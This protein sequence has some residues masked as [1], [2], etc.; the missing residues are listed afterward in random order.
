MMWLSGSTTRRF[1]DN[2]KVEWTILVGHLP[3]NA[4]SLAFVDNLGHYSQVWSVF[5]QFGDSDLNLEVKI[6]PEP[7]SP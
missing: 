7:L 4:V 5:R 6:T 3:V 1:V 2:L